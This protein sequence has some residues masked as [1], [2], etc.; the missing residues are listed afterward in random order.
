MFTVSITMHILAAFDKF[1]DSMTAATACK[2]AANG[3]RTIV[4][5]D[6]TLTEAPLTDGGEGFCSILTHSAN[7][8]IEQHQVSGPLGEE[9]DAPIGWVDARKLS[10]A[11]KELLPFSGWKVAI[12]E[13]ASV[14]GLEQVPNAQRH[15]DNCSTAGVG[16]LIRIA[17][18]SD[19]DAILLGIGGSATSD[20]GLGALEALGITGIARN[21]QEITNTTPAQ[22]KF[23]KSF[24]GSIEVEVPP[25]YIA[26]DVDN[27][28]LGARGAVAV[29]GPQKGMQPDEIE[30]FDDLSKAIATKLCEHC[31]RPLS[32]MDVPGSGAAG[33]LGFGLKVTCRAEFVP[34]FELVQ[35]WLDLQTKVIEADIILTGEGKFDRSSLAGK[36]P[37][38]LLERAHSC[39]KQSIVFAGTVDM[40]AVETVAEHF[41]K[42]AV[43]TIT[44][45]GCP[46]PEALANGARNLEVKVSEVIHSALLHDC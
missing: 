13:M 43:Y 23:L 2:A 22:W 41:P 27:P 35:S 14:A 12:I 10:D 33:G 21:G 20:L 40:V 8:H 24:S 3:S 17:V 11:T 1:K 44:P 16:E 7:G 15:P 9:I 4:G 42:S 29:Y 26:C 39:G 5:E 30:S 37:Y 46:L 36:G 45:E 34:G 28:L 31:D 19:A 6:I 38:S 32:L 18:A 25:I